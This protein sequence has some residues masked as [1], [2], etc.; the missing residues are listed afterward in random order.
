MPS[1]AAVPTG[2]W[3]LPGP[4][5]A[6][7]ALER[8]EHRRGGPTLREVVL[9]KGGTKGNAW[10]RGSCWPLAASITAAGGLGLRPAM[11]LRPRPPQCPLH[12]ITTVGRG[13]G[14]EHP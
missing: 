6:P 5:P 13:A 4:F 12:F 1:E 7:S 8:R 9:E 10:E 3:P 14:W 11:G 2:D